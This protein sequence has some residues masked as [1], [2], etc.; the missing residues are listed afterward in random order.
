MNRKVIIV[1]T[2]FQEKII[3]DNYEIDE[4]D[5]V[6][7]VDNSSLKVGDH[8]FI[9]DFNKVHL[10]IQSL[11][12]LG[13][14][15]RQVDLRCNTLISTQIN[16]LNSLVFS[17]V[18]NPVNRVLIDDG[19]GT[20]AL[21]KEPNILFANKRFWVRFN[22]VRLLILLFYRIDVLSV[23][24]RI[25]TIHRYDSVYPSLSDFIAVPFHV[26]YLRPLF[27]GKLEKKKYKLIV[28]SPMVEFGLMSLKGYEEV[29]NSLGCRN[30]IY[31]PHPD[32][33]VEKEFNYFRTII[34][35]LTCEGFIKETGIPSN[36][37]SFA[38]SVALNV[39][40]YSKVDLT[41]LE[42]TPR[43]YSHIYTEILAKGYKD[44]NVVPVNFHGLL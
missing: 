33:R 44:I 11:L 34:S 36:L 23:K 5:I 43:K 14:I 2:K 1:E 15:R 22:I 37:I 6:I 31:I 19:I 24:N 21:L 9:C 12:A 42:Y 13:K 32:E 20:P 28:G 18:I 41:I 3:A 8:N 4:E 27:S 40:E 7:T 38:S 30:T 29:M 39:R 35:P 25:K 10:W 26:Q 16:G 17:S